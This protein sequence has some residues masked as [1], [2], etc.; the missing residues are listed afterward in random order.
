MK[1][2]DQCVISKSV[3][4]FP[5][6]RLYDLKPYYDSVRPCIFFGCYDDEDFQA[7]RAHNGMVVIWWCGQDAL[8]FQKWGALNKLNIFHVTERVKVFE[9]VRDLGVKIKLNPCSNLAEPARITP[10]GNKIFAY[11]PASFPE[12]HGIDV[13]RELQRVI[14]YEIIMG[15]GSIHQDAWRKGLCNP[16]YNSCFI[17]LVLSPFAGGGATV[18][19]LG[20]RGRKC[21]TNVVQLGNV[22]N[23]E[24]VEDVKRSIEEQSKYIG[25]FRI[26]TVVETLKSLD[27]TN[28]FLE[29]DQYELL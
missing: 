24:T 5:F 12:Y 13:I 11:C 8:D 2:I 27:F 9:H 22:I 4:D 18:I 3:H 16:Y 10:L 20:M 17:G 29:L 6:N 23:W 28:K 15:D 1:R 25:Q 19:E 14:P 7:I 21:I 26:N